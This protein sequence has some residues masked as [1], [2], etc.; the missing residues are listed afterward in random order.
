MKTMNSVVG[1]MEAKKVD[2]YCCYW[3]CCYLF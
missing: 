3:Y 2:N 1:K